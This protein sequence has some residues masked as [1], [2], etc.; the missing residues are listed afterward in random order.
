MIAIKCNEIWLDIPTD[1]T[2]RIDEEMP[3]FSSSVFQGD[4]SFPIELPW[5]PNNCAALGHLWL[6]DVVDKVLVHEVEVYAKT[7][8]LGQAKLHC[9][10]CNERMVSVN[11]VMGL[12]GLSILDRKLSEFAYAGTVT[13]GTDTA[14]VIA[15]AKAINLITAPLP[16]YRFPVIRNDDF[17]GNANVDFEG[18]INNWNSID[19]TVN[20]GFGQPELNWNTL[21]P[22]PYLLKVLEYCFKEAGY[23]IAG[24]F[25]RDENAQRMLL[26]SNFALD[27]RLPWKDVEAESTT[28]YNYT[29]P[30]GITWFKIEFDTEIADAYGFFDPALS[31]YELEFGGKHVA[32]IDLTIKV[33][34]ASPAAIS[35]RVLKEG[36]QQDIYTTTTVIIGTN[37]VSCSLEWSNTIYQAME[38]IT[39][40]VQVPDGIGAQDFQVRASHMLIT[41]TSPSIINCYATE[42]NLAN[43]VPDITLAE[44]LRR[45]RGAPFFL[46][47]SLDRIGRKVN[48]N[49]TQDT[50][51][52]PPEHDFTDKIAPGSKIEFLDQATGYTIKMG[53]PSGDAAATDFGE[54]PSG[55]YIGEY[56]SYSGLPGTGVNIG[57]IAMVKNM[58][59]Y[60]EAVSISSGWTWHFKKYAYPNVIVGDGS[61]ELI[62]EITPALMNTYSVGL[63]PFISQKG[64]SDIFSIGRYSF[65]DTRLMYWHGLM[66]GPAGTYPFA[67]SLN[68]EY[69]GSVVNH[70]P[71][72]NEGTDGLYVSKQ[73]KWIQVLMNGELLRGIANLTINDLLKFPTGRIKLKFQTYFLRKRSTIWGKT[74]QSTEV[75]LLKL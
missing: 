36:V 10:S 56:L 28:W 24:D 18:A 54:A 46:D 44:L 53:W 32:Q 15:H 35:V 1:A 51:S 19:F 23:E 43:H 64:Q 57:A 70:M 68:I 38:D 63:V 55:E 6:T 66:P 2:I 21:V 11:L 29:H 20:I 30:L 60:F 39:F 27:K 40:E 13:I 72:R 61:Q 31:T 48:F 73:S 47:M 9:I 58:N 26:Y 45:L 16:D 12:A 52:R 59:A 5:T 50:L 75:E 7:V 67:T 34:S 17:Y 8:N 3:H 49:Y 33:N 22:Q 42:I 69:Y 37:T 71:M 62:A 14:S 4:V 25:V 41:N 74:I 65:Q